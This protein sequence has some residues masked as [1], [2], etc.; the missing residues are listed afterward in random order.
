VLLSLRGFEEDKGD[1]I[2]KYNEEEARRLKSLGELPENG[3][4][5]C[6]KSDSQN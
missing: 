6:V 3:N 5:A 4:T 2:Q 1:I